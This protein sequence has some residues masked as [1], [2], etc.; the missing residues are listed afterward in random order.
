M[1]AGS[2]PS[3]LGQ[4]LRW[5]AQHCR[6]ASGSG[7]AAAA[8]TLSSPVSQRSNLVRI[9]FD[10]SIRWKPAFRADRLAAPGLVAGCYTVGKGARALDAQSRTWVL[11]AP[12][13][14]PALS[15]SSSIGATGEEMDALSLCSSGPR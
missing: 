5:L 3:G 11:F 12:A 1:T 10:V 14:G 8:G 9:E 15:P 4:T 13:R 6:H 7:L 2:I